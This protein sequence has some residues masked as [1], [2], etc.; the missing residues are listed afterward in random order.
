MQCSIKIFADVDPQFN[1]LKTCL[2]FIV[3]MK[4]K[5]ELYPMCFNSRKAVWSFNDQRMQA[6]KEKPIECITF[7]SRIDRK[8]KKPA[9]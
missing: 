1:N 4:Y 3:Q 2:R 6:K 7:D 8:L 5:I 9:C